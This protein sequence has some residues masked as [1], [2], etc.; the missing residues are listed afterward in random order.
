MVLDSTSYRLRA[1]RNEDR[2]ACLALFDGNVPKYFAIEERQDFVSFLEK[3]P[4]PYFVMVNEQEEVVAC[5]GYATSEKN[6]ELAVLCWG[7]VRRDLHRHGVGTQLLEERLRLIAAEPHLSIVMIETSQHSCGF[8][9]RFGFMVKRVVPNGFAQGL[10][11]VEMKLELLTQVVRTSCPELALNTVEPINAGQNSYILL[12]NSEWVFRFPKYEAGVRQ[13]SREAAILDLIADRVPLEVP[14]PVYRNADA[15]ASARPFIGYRKIEGEPLDAELLQQ[16]G[17]EVIVRRL[18]G[19]LAE[20]LRELH[21]VN[22]D[23]LLL[24]ERQ[25]YNAYAEWAEL[26]ERIQTKLYPHLKPDARKWT[27]Q[28]FQAFLA[29][30][31]GTRIVPTLI[32][33][34][35]GTTNILYDATSQQISGILDFGSAGLGDPAVDYAALRASYGEHFFQFLVNE[36][37]Q[38]SALMDRV[39]FYQGTFALQEALFGLENGDEEAFRAGIDAAN[40]RV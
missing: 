35:F 12:I 33:G 38:L 11:L 21:R 13:L 40:A 32:H 9:E 18:A 23:E 17:D 4:G 8:F 39:L 1:Y 22:T 29:S 10:D 25:N 37:P 3:L 20:F 5:G 27:E 34:D 30:E 14:R 36:N 6:R 2:E 15:S 7:M 26:Y 31:A 16:I 28:H 24:E 19:Q